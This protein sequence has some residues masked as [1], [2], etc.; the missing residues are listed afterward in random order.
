M[1]EPPSLPAQPWEVYAIRFS[2]LHRRRRDALLL[3]PPATADDP[4]DMDYSMWVA[5]SGQETIVIDT[6]YSPE[7]GE[8]LGRTFLCDPVEV[9]RDLGV[10]PG[11]VEDVVLT[12]FHYD[13]AGN[14]DAFPA[15]TIHVHEAELPAAAWHVGEPALAFAYATE[16]VAAAQAAAAEGRLHL[17]TGSTTLRP[18]I[19]LHQMG[20]HTPGS[21]A[22]QIWTARGWLLLAGDASHIAANARERRPYPLFSDLRRTFEDYDALNR[23]APDPDL[24]VPGHEASVIDRYPPARPDLAG[25]V[26]R[27]DLPPVDGPSPASPR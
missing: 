13:H 21:M 15:A 17:L 22:V 19:E 18:G 5:R 10:E 16:H 14:L 6:G 26:A 27:L 7:L 11:S 12:H 2:R 9:V 4:I 23:L 3:C 1:S 25:R 20:G 8:R 24:L